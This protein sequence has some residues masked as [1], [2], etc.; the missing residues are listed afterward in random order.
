MRAKEARLILIVDYLASKGI[1]AVKTQKSGTEWWYHSPIRS[2][3]KHPSFKV[4]TVKNLWFDFGRAIGGN[5]LDL[6]CR[7]ESMTVREALAFLSASNGG[8][9]TN[10]PTSAIPL[11]HE[12]KKI[13]SFKKV[14]GE[15]EKIA[16][17][18]VLSLGVIKKKELVHYLIARCIDLSIAKKYLQ[19]IHYKPV[20][21]L[22]SYYA[23]ALPCGDGFEARSAFFKGFIGQH[24]AIAKI[25]LKS[26]LS[27]SIFEGVMDFLAFL[28]YYSKQEF[29]SSVIILNSINLRKKA[30]V[31]I[32]KF[33]FN[34]V[35]LFLDN[36]AAGKTT[37]DFFQCSIDKTI[38]VIDKS[39]IYGD[40]QDFNAMLMQKVNK[41]EFI[42]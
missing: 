7:L 39:D 13:K 38:S 22:K 8:L 4:D 34:K 32:E 11:F 27:L 20:H 2:G 24:K 17:F 30:L 12:E 18:Q 33:N 23:L 19:E 10:K 35:Y 28:T 26:G 31:E 36:D 42:K 25:N 3:D 5:T 15:K 37:R 14:A 29:K 40:Y 1:H 41:D 6:V 16:S 9:Q 21:S